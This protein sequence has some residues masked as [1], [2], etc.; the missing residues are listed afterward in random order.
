MLDP[1]FD[2]REKVQRCGECSL[3]GAGSEECSS[4]LLEYELQDVLPRMF[5]HQVSSAINNS[6]L[7]LFSVVAVD[8][9]E[10]AVLVVE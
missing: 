1:T 10:V 3:C 7:F 4:H 2:K 9:V 6:Q 5:L 8:I